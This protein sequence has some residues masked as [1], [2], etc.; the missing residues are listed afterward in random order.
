MSGSSTRPPGLGTRMKMNYESRAQYHLPRRTYT[1]VRVDGKAF[2]TYCR[3]LEKPFDP[4]LVDD[5]IETTRHLCR[6][7]QGACLGYV[8]SDEISVLLTDFAEPSTH[9]WFDGNVQKIASVTASLAA[10][11]FNQLRA[12]R[13]LSAEFKEIE[14][15]SPHDVVRDLELA[16]F[17]ART[18]TI[19]DP[20]EVANYL[21]WR[22]LDALR[23]AVHGLGR[24]HFSQAELQNVSS[25]E[26]QEKLR[27]ERGVDW[28]RQLEPWHRMGTL[29]RPSATVQDVVVR[30]PDRPDV[31]IPDVERRVWE[32]VTPARW[33]VNAPEL[34]ELIP[35]LRHLLRRTE[36]TP[37]P[38]EV[39]T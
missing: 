14:Y 32:A 15:V 18:F 26:L 4:G 28:Q 39:A 38:N 7:M 23:N 22:Q 30:R 27:D 36:P 20:V 16:A 19:P 1:I 5:M 8:Q 6:S 12:L 25:R 37:E 21:I 29:L 24:I 31:V 34:I 13:A 10:A 11:R 9:A 2:H 17:D 33:T 35:G 3:N